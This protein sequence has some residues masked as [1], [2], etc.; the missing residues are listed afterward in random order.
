MQTF[1]RL[2]ELAGWSWTGGEFGAERLRE[3]ADRA[4]IPLPVLTSLRAGVPIAYDE[5]RRRFA[6][7]DAEQRLAFC[8]RAIVNDADADRLWRFDQTIYPAE[9]ALDRSLYLTAAKL[10][11]ELNV[12]YVQED[13][14]VV[15]HLS[16]LP[17]RG[18]AYSAMR[19]GAIHE[20]DLSAADLAL[21]GK[22]YLCS[23]YAAHR[24]VGLA[25]Q[26]DLRTF[27]GGWRGVFGA[28][29]VTAAGLAACERLGLRRIREDREEWQR[30][31]IEIVPVFLERICDQA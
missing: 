1:V 9:K 11:P 26:A 8:R 19:E 17:L 10:A 14:G 7:L 22:L 4:L 16:C 3:I 21:D 15:G 30:T 23:M 28:Y 20:G 27:L 12:L 29:A 24:D 31:N 2:E 6:F 5:K 13:D 25:L 18:D